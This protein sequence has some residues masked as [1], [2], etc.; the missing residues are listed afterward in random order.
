MTDP[1]IEFLEGYIDG[2]KQ[3]GEW[4]EM[5]PR[6]REVSLA[7]ARG[8]SEGQQLLFKYLRG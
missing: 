8:Y 2:L 5:T 7:D 1:T 6:E 4:F 3:T